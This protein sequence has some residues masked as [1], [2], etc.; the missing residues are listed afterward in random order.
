MKRVRLIFATTLLL[1]L[2]IAACNVLKNEDNTADLRKF[3]SAFQ[4][5]LILP[6]DEILKQFASTQSKESI[7]SAIRILQ[8]K[9][10]EYIECAVDFSSFSIVS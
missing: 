9:E 3:M 2:V 1:T 10:S 6:D 5:S 8:N 4:A 7:L